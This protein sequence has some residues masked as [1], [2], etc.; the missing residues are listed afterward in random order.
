M[1]S[2]HLNSSAINNYG[3]TIVTRGSD[4]NT[5]HILVASRDRDVAVIMLC[6]TRQIR[7]REATSPWQT[8]S[9]STHQSDLVWLSA[10]VDRFFRR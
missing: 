8:S 9:C 4:Q 1:A 3:G 10:T 6:L 5:R 7:V 2:T